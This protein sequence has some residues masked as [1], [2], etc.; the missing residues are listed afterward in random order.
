MGPSTDSNKELVRRLVEQVWNGHDAG[1]LRDYVGPD[2]LEESAEHTAQF[3]DAFPD[4]R[5]TIDDVFGE[6]DKVAARLTITGTHL[7]PFAGHAPT[8]KRVSFASFRI[9][10]VAAGKVIETWAMQDRLALLQQL[11]ILPHA[12]H[13]VRWLGEGTR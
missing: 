1:A 6:G 5:V 8:G 2:L 3:L 11:E 12:E 7:G 4:V 10:R 13:G 9:Y